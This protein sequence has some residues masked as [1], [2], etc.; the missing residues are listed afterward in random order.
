MH[1]NHK[2]KKKHRKNP[3]MYFFYYI[4][5]WKPLSTMLSGYNNT[6]KNRNNNKFIQFYVKKI[7][8]KS[9]D[10]IGLFFN[11]FINIHFKEH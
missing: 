8:L 10:E 4:L 7:I 11:F 3:N 5:P 2:H 9:A 1:Y 6:T